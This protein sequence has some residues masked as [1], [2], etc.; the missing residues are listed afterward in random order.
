MTQCEDGRDGLR[1][2][3]DRECRP[4]TYFILP[5][6]RSMPMAPVM[7][8]YEHRTVSISL[9]NLAAQYAGLQESRCRLSEYHLPHQ[10]PP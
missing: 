1:S 10:R 7:I 8:N 4:D 9:G 2:E 5:P 3:A 6:V